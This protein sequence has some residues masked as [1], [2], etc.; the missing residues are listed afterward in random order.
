MAGVVGMRVPLC[1]RHLRLEGHG[2]PNGTESHGR[3]DVSR[4]CLLSRFLGAR[5]VDSPVRR[6]T[7]AAPVSSI[8]AQ[9]L[10]P[11]GVYGTGKSTVAGAIGDELEARGLPFAATDLD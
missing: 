8:E 10:L 3:N 1:R 5:R 2:A 9:G 4:N 7:Y 11:T 6:P